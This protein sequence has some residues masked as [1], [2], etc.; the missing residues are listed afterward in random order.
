MPHEEMGDDIGSA[1]VAVTRTLKKLKEKNLV[2]VDRG[3]IRLIDKKA[4]YE[5]IS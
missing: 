1:S 2:A 3:A 5:I 4:L